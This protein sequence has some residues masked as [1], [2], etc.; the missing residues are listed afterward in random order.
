MSGYMSSIKKKLNN[1][2]D[3]AN[4]CESE[5]EL[6]SVLSTS[7]RLED[8]IYSVMIYD[9]DGRLLLYGNETN[10]KAKDSATDMLLDKADFFAASSGFAVTDPHV[11][12]MY[13]NKYPWVV[14]IVRQ[15]YSSLFKQQVYVAV[16]YKFSQIATYIDNISIGQRGYC[17]IINSK[18]DVVYHPQQ[19]M[20][21]SGIKKENTDRIA[22]MTDGT[23]IEKD[24]I[25]CLMSMS[26]CN[27]RIV[28]VSYND[29]VT[30]SVREQ[31][32]VGF[33][34]ALLFSMLI[35]LVIYLIL[36]RT[37]TRPVRRLVSSMQEFEKQAETFKYNADMSNVVEFQT[38]S[39]SFEHMVGMI[40]SLME[41]VHNEEIILRR[42]NSKPCR[43][44]LI[45]TFV[46]HP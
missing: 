30:K 10:D 33:L 6:Q 27:W 13:R 22:K 39:A 41:K 44:R 16:D 20:L 35:S 3:E 14:T 11:N 9:D 40:Q 32:L 37:V 12:A 15:E 31:L 38:L 28:G 29:E 42:R 17:Y 34:F 1:L 26:G 24:N 43:H 23:H 18:G 2:C 19:Q 46:Q 7:A 36:S 4:S 8:D 21:F 5:K 25:Y 45:L